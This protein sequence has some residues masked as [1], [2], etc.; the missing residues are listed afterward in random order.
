MLFYIILV[1]VVVVIFVTIAYNLGSIKYE[2]DNLLLK[3]QLM[4]KSERLKR[5]Y[6][7]RRKERVELIKLRRFHKRIKRMVDAR[8]ESKM[9]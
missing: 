3:K 8:R 6:K 1:V 7:S 2:Q 4:Y 5:S 9:G